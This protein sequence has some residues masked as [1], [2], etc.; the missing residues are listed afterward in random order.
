MRTSIAAGLLA[1]LAAPLATSA[2]D[3]KAFDEALLHYATRGFSGSVVIARKGEVLLSGGYGFADFA[4]NRPNDANTLFEI[5]S[6]TKSFTATAVVKLA[7]QGALALDDSIADRLPGVP[8]HS[9]KITLR[10][11]LSHTAGI[12]RSQAAGRGEDLGQAVATYLGTGPTSPP[13]SKYEYW[14]GG[15][16][17]LA[18]V[19]ERASGGSY[20]AYLERELFAPAGMSDSGFTGDTDL[21]TDRDAVGSSFKGEDRRALEHPYSSYGYQYRGMGGLVTSVADLLK[22]ESALAR[23]QLLDEAHTKELFEPIQ[24]GYALGWRIGRAVNGHPRQW[25]GGS[26]RGFVSEFRRYPADGCCIAI[27]CNRDDQNLGEIADNL[28]CL[29]FGLPL[30]T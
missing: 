20:T 4:A 26:V 5:A 24:D 12:P 8:P 11:L 17:L 6:M 23:G 22:W 29:L 28:E 18:G 3:R 14:N 16:A 9:S 25:H 2:P 19:I 7:Q 1:L 13:G 10:H 15:Y 30:A 21:G 27:L